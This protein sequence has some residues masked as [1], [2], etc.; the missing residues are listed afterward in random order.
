MGNELLILLPIFFGIALIYSSAGFGGG[1]SYIAVLA[2]FPIEFASIRFIALLCN[3][4]VVSASVL[5]FYSS[6]FL[7]LKRIW[8]LII[9][10]IPLAYLGG[11]F[12]MEETL[13]FILLGFTLLGA[14]LLML[15]QPAHTDSKSWPIYTH[16]VIGGGIGFLSGL[17]GIGGGIFLSPVLHLTKW[18]SPKTIA[19]TTALFILVNS[20]AGLLGQLS[21]NEMNLEITNLLA[22]M[23]AVFLGGQIGSRLTINKLAP[24]TIKK[25]SGLL[26]LV[27]SIRLLYKYL[28]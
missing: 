21:T 20:I 8:P 3:I 23:A 15:M 6:G 14:S 1:S 24:V 11:R 2:L 19:A 5:L 7:K 9:L 4:T 27:V 10:S 22:L 16:G 13:F 17:V 18:A 12:R 26:I 25:I 28:F